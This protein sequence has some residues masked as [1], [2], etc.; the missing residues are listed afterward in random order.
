[1]FSV[2]YLI[3][4]PPTHSVAGSIVLFSGVCRRLASVIGCRLSGSVTL[5]GVS[6]CGFT[7]AGYYIATFVGELQFT[8]KDNFVIVVQIVFVI[9]NSGDSL[10]SDDKFDFAAADFRVVK[11]L[12]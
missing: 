1:M 11:N 5:L 9:V 2:I 6:A 12:L 8:I 4:G 10:E 7:R 3:T